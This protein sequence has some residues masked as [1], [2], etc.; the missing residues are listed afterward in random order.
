MEI[1]GRVTILVDEDGATIEIQD[2]VANTTFCRIKMSNEQFMRCLGR[3]AY[4]KPDSLDVY[5]LDRVGKVHECK[6]FEFPMPI[7]AK[8]HW[9]NREELAIRKVK[10]DCPE[11]WYPD[12]YFNSQNSFFRKDDEDW[13][14]CIIRRYV[15]KD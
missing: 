7:A 15:D 2:N 13:A 14:R 10:S 8:I 3:G 5:G 11:G 9:K 6:Q 1:D 4:T 12:L